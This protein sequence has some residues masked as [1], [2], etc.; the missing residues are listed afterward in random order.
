MSK[1]L[2]TSIK[3]KPWVYSFCAK[4]RR[5]THMGLKMFCVHLLL[6]LQLQRPA[7]WGKCAL[8]CVRRWTVLGDKWWRLFNSWWQVEGPEV[9]RLLHMPLKWIPLHRLSSPLQ[10]HIYLLINDLLLFSLGFHSV[11]L[12]LIYSLTL[13]YKNACPQAFVRFSVYYM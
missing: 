6:C 1:K 7:V 3:K 4:W 12:G 11:S 10:R 9:V 5:F 13:L 8:L 2:V